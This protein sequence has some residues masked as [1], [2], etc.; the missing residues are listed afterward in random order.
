MKKPSQIFAETIAQSAKGNL[1]FA[2]SEYSQKFLLST[3]LFDLSPANLQEVEILSESDTHLKIQANSRDFLFKSS[4]FKDNRM[5]IEAEFRLIDDDLEVFV[6]AG[7][8]NTPDKLSGL[9]GSLAELLKPLDILR[10]QDMLFILASHERD[11]IESEA[12]EEYNFL[13]ADILPGINLAAFI[14]F[15]KSGKVARLMASPVETVIGYGPHF[16]TWNVNGPANVEFSLQIPDEINIENVFM[17]KNPAIKIRPF[18][19]PQFSIDG[20]FE[21]DL[22]SVPALQIPGG[23]TFATNGVRGQFVLDQAAELLKP[24][25]V[26]DGIRFTSLSVLAGVVNGKANVG[27]EGSFSIGS[28]SPAA[29]TKAG[30]KD[31][32]D[33]RSNEYKFI[34]DAIPGKV[35]PKFAYLY[36]DTLSLEIY[37]KAISGQHVALPPF[38]RNISLEQVMMHWCDN[39]LGEIK[40]DGTIALPVFGLS[41]I[42]NIFGHKTFAEIQVGVDGIS[43]GTFMADPI[44]LGNGLLQITGNGKG[45]PVG[46]KGGVKIRPGGPAFS[47]NS[48]GKPE[49]LAFTAAIKILGIEGTAEG[50]AG[51]EGLHARVTARVGNVIKGKME[52]MMSGAD[53]SAS[54]YIYA[55]IS[56]KRISLGIL[57][58]VRLDTR[59]EGAFSAALQKGVYSNSMMLG[60]RFIGK[61]FSLGELRIEVRELN[62]ITNIVEDEIRKALMAIGNQVQEWLNAAYSGVITFA[63]DAM[64]AIGKALNEHF[65]QNMD[66]AARL[67]RQTGYAARQ[68]GQALN[69]GYKRSR[70]EVT[71]ALRSAGYAASEVGD[72][73][74][75]VFKAGAQEIA[76]LMRAAGFSASDVGQVLQHVFKVNAQVAVGI[77]QGAGYTA[78]QVGG[79][80]QTVYKVPASFANAFIKGAGSVTKSA[81]NTAKKAFRSIRRGLKL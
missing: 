65:K 3:G 13:N 30:K 36:L 48:D 76:G 45:S 67:M 16:L 25:F 60:F 68:V 27:A 57:G 37:I 18:Q 70:Q 62:K 72:A 43:S 12:F 54:A 63:G 73:L 74:S 23:F 15:N 61:D 47:F 42:A 26:Y 28:T 38:L 5:I 39:P 10:V 80:L 59:L 6:V 46:Y 29:H 71:R 78:Q 21:L 81:G 9:P 58:T 44:R 51:D 1:Q 22:P 35:I 52:L 66:N 14:D 64:E 53:F 41:C 31:M 77:L 7:L 11:H 40:P 50:E 2:L 20:L 79:A 75:F 34:F 4:V 8:E 49:Y 69:K 19:P 24:P 56:N 55:G 17:I 32:A 33:M